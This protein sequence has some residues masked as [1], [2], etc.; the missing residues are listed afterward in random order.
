MPMPKSLFWIPA[1]FIL[2][3]VLALAAC[4][5]GEPGPTATPWPTYPPPTATPSPELP[6]TNAASMMVYLEQ[7]DYQSEWELWPGFGEKYL[8]G[9][10]HSIRLTTYVN[11]PAYGAVI[12][13]KGVLP[14]DSI[15]VKEN[16]TED[17]EFKA[18]TVMYKVEGY[19]PEHNDWFW[20]KVLADGTVDQ[21]G[22][23]DGCQVC[24]AELKD[25]DYI[26][27]GGPT[28]LSE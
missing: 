2:S 23:P 13:K 24:H 27:T 12:G 6:Q 16:Y 5:S 18:T 17:G 21:E 14:P 10:T 28:S 9:G 20:L 26:W 8:T 25:N 19:N 15:I 1:V 3:A 22:R 11:P 4:G 7:A